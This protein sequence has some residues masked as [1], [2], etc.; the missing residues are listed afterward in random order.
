AGQTFA[1]GSKQIVN[2]SFRPTLSAVGTVPILF[3]DGPVIREVSD[4]DATTVAADY[5]NGAIV[6][7]PPPSLRI[8]AS[9]DSITLSWPATASGFVL[10]ESTNPS[11]TLAN[12]TAV[13][14]R[15]ALVHN[16]NVVSVPLGSTVRFFRLFQP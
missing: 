3:G 16:L 9:G 12:W 5:I 1:V 10:Q 15:P 2:I 6:I 11:L 13:R 7:G 14:A 8:T 4:P